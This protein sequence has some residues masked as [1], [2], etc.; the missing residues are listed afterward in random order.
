M[1]LSTLGFI[2]YLAPTCTLLLALF[3]YGENVPHERWLTFALIWAALLLFSFEGV[4]RYR[5][6]RWR[7][8]RMITLANM[9][10]QYYVF[11]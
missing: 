7:G 9:K 6:E 10:R 11:D 5:R 2:Q 4:Y 8:Q 3:V 1:P